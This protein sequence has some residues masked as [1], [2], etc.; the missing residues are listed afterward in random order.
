[1]IRFRCPR[2]GEDLES[3]VELAGGMATC[4]ACDKLTPVPLRGIPVA[5]PV[6]KLAENA[7]PMIKGRP[8]DGWGNF[9][10]VLVMAGLILV[11]LWF[12][13]FRNA[14]SSSSKYDAPPDFDAG[15][16]EGYEDG[17]EA[18]KEDR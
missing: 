2:C 15:Y 18:G 16:G 14:P 13:C 3:P 1:M 6:E 4:P 9:L 12:T 5:E 17:Y 11:G 10:L 7:E 8:G